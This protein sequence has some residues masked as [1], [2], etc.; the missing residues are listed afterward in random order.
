MND[1]RSALV[2]TG[3]ALI[4]R[5]LVTG[6]FGNASV[7]LAPDRILVTPS[8]LEYARMTADD[9][10]VIDPSGRV[11]DGDRAATSEA[12]M[13]LAVYAA[14]PDTQAI[15]HTHSPYATTLACIPE[16]IE[17]IHYL[18]AGIGN[19]VPVAPYATFGTPE[20][21]AAAAAALGERHQAVLLAQH[22][23]LAVGSD[24]DQALF[25]A[26]TVE[27]V[28]A[29][30]CRLRAMGITPTPLTPQRLDDTHRRFYR[31]AKRG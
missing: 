26:E 25:V 6:A 15:I 30:T 17:P 8:G 27:Y 7:R 28:A 20:I 14:R 10:V 12:P 31:R 29:I 2:A 23:V 9:L 13:H 3:R 16:P 19:V 5:G 4:E 18:M 24:L 11:I 22:G 1:A 21:G